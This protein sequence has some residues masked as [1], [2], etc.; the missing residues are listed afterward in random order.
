MAKKLIVD[1]AYLAKHAAA[2]T[3]VGTPPKRVAL[4]GECTVELPASVNGP[5]KKVFVPAP[6]QAELAVL[7]SAGHKYIIEI[8]DEPTAAKFATQKDIPAET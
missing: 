7:K 2:F 6:T 4:H 8:Q 3:T 5:A 1:P